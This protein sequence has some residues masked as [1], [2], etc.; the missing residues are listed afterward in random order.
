MGSPLRGCTRFAPN[1][2]V[3]EHLYPLPFPLEGRSNV[4]ASGHYLQCTGFTLHET[5]VALTIVGILTVTAFG[6]ARIV[7]STQMTTQVN[8][9][10]ADLSLA[11]TEAIKRGQTITVCKSSSGLDCTEDSQW[12]EGWLVFTDANENARVDGNDVRLKV[13]QA[14]AGTTRLTF[15]A[16]GPGT[17]KYVNYTSNGATKQNGTFRFCDRSGRSIAKAVILIQTGR[18]RTAKTNVTCP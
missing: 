2:T 7:Q 9:L 18:A 8:T 4:P 6:F 15:S 16:W 17:G 3:C 11:R 13:G 5:L 12:H 10:I 1:E 14:L